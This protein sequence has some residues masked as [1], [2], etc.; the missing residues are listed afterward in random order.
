MGGELA[1]RSMLTLAGAA[2]AALSG[3]GSP[4]EQMRQASTTPL[5]PPPAADTD[6]LMFIRHAE[7]ALSKGAPYGVAESGERDTRSLIVRGWMR[8][9]ALVE[10]FDPRGPDGEQIAT[11]PGILRPTT[12]FAHNPGDADSKRSFETASPLAAS[13]KL[14]VDIRYTMKQTA[15]LSAT[16]KG[17]HGPVLVAWRHEQIA[18]II[19]GLGV[20]TPPPPASWPENRY[21]MVFVLTRN[22]DGW[23]FR[24]V[25]QMLLAGDLLTPIG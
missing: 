6:V 22:G 25:P 21:D 1:R 11:R 3:C 2:A 17:M 7:D 15:Q 13:L 18:T 24:Q 19:A 16:L 10:L 9:G 23:T 5:A 8:A 4:P 14:P 12:I 20:V